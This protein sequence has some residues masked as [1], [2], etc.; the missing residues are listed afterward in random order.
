[1]LL[2]KN[3]ILDELEEQMHIEPVEDVIFWA[4]EY[5]AKRGNG[6]TGELAASAIVRRI[7][8]EEKAKSEK[9]N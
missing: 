7:R 1:M 2:S 9:E 8:D 6:T 4:L 5:Y 3:I